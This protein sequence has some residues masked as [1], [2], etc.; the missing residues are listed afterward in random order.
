MIGIFEDEEGR[1]AAQLEGEAQAAAGGGLADAAADFAAAGEGQLGQAFAL[2]EGSAAFIA[3]GDDIDDAGRQAGFGEDF[4]EAEGAE[5]G[6]G[7]GFD[8][9]GVAGGEGG[10][11]LPGQHEEGKIPGDDLADDAQ[12][13]VLREGMRQELGPAGVV[14]EMADGERDIQVARFADGLAVIERF[15]DGEQAGVLLHGAGDG[16]EVAGALV[17]G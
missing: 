5:A 17:G 8:D 15:E 9:D 12:R 7:R 6:L 1:F 10:G 3:A 14:V 11:D 4:G 13:L 2:D 16:V